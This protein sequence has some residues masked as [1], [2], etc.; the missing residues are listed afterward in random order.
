MA[1][2][3]IYKQSVAPTQT[4]LKSRRAKQSSFCR[5]E[6]RLLTTLPDEGGLET[7]VIELEEHIKKYGGMNNYPDGECFGTRAGTSQNRDNYICGDLDGNGFLNVLDI[8]RLAQC[9]L[10]DYCHGYGCIA[11]LNGDWNGD[12]DAGGFNV[13]DIVTLANCVLADNQNCGS[14]CS[15]VPPIPQNVIAHP[16]FECHIHHGISD[17]FTVQWDPVGR[18]G[19]V[20]YNVYVLDVPCTDCSCIAD[21][22]AF[23]T[24]CPDNAVECDDSEKI[25]ATGISADEIDDYIGNVFDGVKCYRVT[26]VDSETGIE[27]D[28]SVAAYVS[29]CTDTSEANPNCQACCRGS[30]MCTHELAYDCMFNDGNPGTP[31]GEDSDCF[32]SSGGCAYDCVDCE[33]PDGEDI[34]DCGVC[35]GICFGDPNNPPMSGTCYSCDCV[36]GEFDCA[37]VCNG[38]LELDDCGDCDG[39][40][41]DM[42]CAGECGGSA[43]EDECGE[44]GGDGSSC[45]VVPG[46]MDMDACNYNEY[47]TEDDGNCLQDDCAYVCGGDS[48]E[49]ICG[50]CGQGD[51]YWFCGGEGPDVQWPDAT[52]CDCGCD[53]WAWD[54]CGNCGGECNPPDCGNAGNGWG[55]DDCDECLDGVLV[56]PGGDCDDCAGVPNGDSWEGDY[57]DDCAGTPNGDV[58]EDD[59]GTCGGDI[60]RCIFN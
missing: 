14:C 43:V 17:N 44:C 60:T 7:W 48:Y 24:I 13:L 6:E 33:C 27:S 4:L 31:Y 11:D 16:C 32:P 59:C 47:A 30:N 12:P 52:S 19:H 15:G 53:G 45:A 25:E 40:N 1:K 28:Y 49:D 34:D 37:G 54:L 56:C 10:G 51:E 42:D 46:C 50:V 55:C 58:E 3:R 22:M 20:T 23:A 35:D 26:S 38:T 9:I 21:D 39:G 29:Q 57:C 2:P 5:E 8:V 41:A 18:D 36:S